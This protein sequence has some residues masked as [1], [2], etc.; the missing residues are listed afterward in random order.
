MF[1]KPTGVVYRAYNKVT[2]K[3]YVGKTV[4][5]LSIRKKEH[6][7]KSNTQKNFKFVNALR[8]YSESA[9]EWSILIEVE[10]EKLE[11][12][13]RFFIKELDSIN[14]GYNTLLDTYDPTKKGRNRYD[15]NTTY[16]LYHRDYGAVSANRDELRQIDARLVDKL[17]DLLTNRYCSYRG[18]VLLENKDIYKLRTH[19]HV[20]TLTHSELGTHTL[21]RKEFKEQFNLTTHA[22]SGL[23]RKTIKISKGW[24]LVEEK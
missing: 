18:W 7:K 19:I 23:I 8:Q 12:Y 11:E 4:R 17:S 21:T 2:E 24:S 15:S 9:W 20:T 16:Q 6:I 10:I 1:K 22:I 5:D 13:E 3:S 14:N